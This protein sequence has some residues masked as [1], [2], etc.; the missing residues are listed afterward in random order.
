MATIEIVNYQERWPTEFES[1]A[2][3]MRAALGSNVVRID[4]IGSTSV[5]GLS[6]KDIIDIQISV[7]DLDNKDALLPLE[8]LGYPRP[9]HN[10]DVL[11]GLEDDSPELQKLFLK[12]PAGQRRTNIHVREVGR[13]NQAYPLLFRDY[14]RADSRI[15]EAY[16]MIKIEL[17]ARF[18]EDIDAYYAIKD[19]YMDTVYQ[20]ALL[21]A[22]QNDWQLDQN[23]L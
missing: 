11:V 19:P 22:K 3:A 16:Q 5:P 15:R 23:F 7:S 6:A 13:L 17:A 9:K 14:L 12:E 2:V 21:W 8:K 20:A 4:H 10:N 18:P 1:I